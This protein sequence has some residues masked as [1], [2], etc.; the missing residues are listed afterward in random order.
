VQT[1]CEEPWARNL[2]EVVS[3]ELMCTCSSTS[4]D[5]HTEML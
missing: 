2:L 5:L 4:I 3:V 1:Q